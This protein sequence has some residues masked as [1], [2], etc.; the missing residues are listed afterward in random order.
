[1]EINNKIKEVPKIQYTIKT[2]AVYESDTEPNNEKLEELLGSE[3][4]DP[5]NIKELQTILIDI[6]NFNE[7]E[8]TQYLT[9][10]KEIYLRKIITT[11]N[12]LF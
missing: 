2:Y 6:K 10:K 3:T 7:E 11:N 8:K 1:M 5:L 4:T 12:N 9:K